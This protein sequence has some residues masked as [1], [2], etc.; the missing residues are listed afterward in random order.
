MLSVKSLSVSVALWAAITYT[1]CVVYGLLVP[2]Q[3]HA[4]ELLEAVLPG[5]HW[6]S[7]GSFLIGLVETF[8]YGAYT[9]LVFGVVYNAVQR[10][11]AAA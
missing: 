3:F 11:S 9:G 8:V 7:L 1:L 4:A 5:F 2:P 6:I 10:R